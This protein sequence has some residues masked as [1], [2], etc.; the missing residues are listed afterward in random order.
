MAGITPYDTL[1]QQ[2]DA[3]YSA[4]ANELNFGGTPPTPG[5]GTN[6]TGRLQTVRMVDRS[7]FPDFNALPFVGVQLED[8]V[9]KKWG[10]RRRH[11][12]TSNFTIIIVAQSTVSGEGFEALSSAMSVLRPIMSDG[13][14]NGVLSIL[15]DANNYTLGGNAMTSQIVEGKVSY[16]TA[17]TG[18]GTS[19]IAFATIHFQA[20]QPV[21]LS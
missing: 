18:K 4:L 11:I 15:R 17:A 12:V 13:A 1:V 2:W 20:E 19:Y 6:P 8:F 9:E 14:G 7:I 3:I 16:N 10:M 5:G 21:Q